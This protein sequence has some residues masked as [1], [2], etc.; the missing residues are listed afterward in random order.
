MD[1]FARPL[2]E[3]IAKALGEGLSRN[4]LAREMMESARRLERGAI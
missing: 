4:A 2:R 1:R 3:L